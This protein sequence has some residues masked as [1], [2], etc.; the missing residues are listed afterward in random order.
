MSLDR[1]IAWLLLVG[2]ALLA[3]LMPAQNDTW[4][5]LRA[6][7]DMLA[8]GSVLLTDTYS[9]TVHGGHW[10]NY[11]WLGEVVF[12]L[13]HHAGGMPLLTALCAIAVTGGVAFVYAAM[14]ERGVW[15]PLLLAAIAAGATH[16]WSV[17][18]QA[19]SLLLLGLTLWLTTTGRWRWLP[20]V[21]LVWAN[22]HGAVAYGGVVLAGMIL[23]YLWHERRLPRA[24]VIVAVLCGVATLFTPL[25][26][27]YWWEVAESI[28]RSRINE[29][30]EWRR[31]NLPPD[32]L[33]FWAMAVAL[34]AALALRHR[35]LTTPEGRGVVCAALLFLPL[36]A[37]TM[38]NIT[39]YL[40]VAAAAMTFLIPAERRKRSPRTER[41]LLNVLIA[42]A[43]AAVAAFIVF[44]AWRDR[45]DGPEWQPLPREA[46]AAIEACRPNLYNRYEDGGPIIFFAPA[47]KVLLDSRQ[48]PYP[49]TLVQ[50][51]SDAERTG[52]YE[53]LFDERAID[54]AA[55]TPAS[56]LASRLAGDGWIKRYEDRRWI[57][58]E[59]PH[60]S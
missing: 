37:T 59:R 43:A 8:A 6:G 4:W 31:P 14:R 57:V 15:T 1:F 23:G 56:P 9:H 33:V 34:P 44:Q 36:A 40:M 35:S 55:T 12:A 38:R 48:D 45:I 13:A 47:Q 52:E 18:P 17:R 53:G 32:H 10:P 29:I 24:L 49:T 20:P 28:Q 22:L 41:T 5:H 30:A 26:V 2:I 51:Q 19:F 21:F 25:G 3:C 60:G 16:T 58:L 27:W 46:A 50:Q 39:P 7:Y 11:E 42:S 54:C